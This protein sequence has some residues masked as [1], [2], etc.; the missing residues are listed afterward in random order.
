MRNEL[1]IIL[2]VFLLINAFLFQKYGIK[3]VTDSG[4]YV[5]YAT[6]LRS[7]FYFDPHNFWYIGY[8]LYILLIQLLQGSFT[9]IVAGQYVIAFFAVLALYKTSFIIWKNRR[10]ALATILIYLL[11]IDISS[12]NSYVLTESLYT[13]FTCFSIY[14]LTL[15]Y[16]GKR[17]FWFIALTGILVLFTIFIKPTG[18]ALAG[19]LLSVVMYTFLKQLNNRIVYAGIIIFAGGIFLYLVNRMLTTYLI[20]ENYQLGEVIYAVTTVT[21]RPE[22]KSLVISP[23]EN[24]YQPPVNYPPLLKIISFFFHHPLYWLR[25]FFTKAGYLLLHVRPFWSWG[26][27]LFSLVVLL[28]S[29][30]FCVK[31]LRQEKAKAQVVMFAETYLLIHLLSVCMTS[32]DWDGRFLIPMLPV[33][34]LFTGHGVAGVF[35][36]LNRS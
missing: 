9:A 28:P 22:V 25:L 31:T 16:N 18:I 5:E 1:V 6:T 33:I 30:W 8:S 7:G 26:H 2:L 3:V 12:W 17:D 32:E 14:C 21:D 20:M 23:P 15:M 11:F 34:F 36:K 4:R 24:I 29:Y 27:N 13:S 10:S 35:D 19:A